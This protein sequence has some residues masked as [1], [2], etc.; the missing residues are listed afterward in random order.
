MAENKS[1]LEGTRHDR[2]SS[3][4]PTPDPHFQVPSPSGSRPSMCSFRPCASRRLAL[5]PSAAPAPPAAK[6]QKWIA[7]PL[8]IKGASL[9]VFR[10]IPLTAQSLCWFSAYAEL[11]P[12][13]SHHPPHAQD[14]ITRSQ[15][16]D[17]E[18]RYGRPRRKFS[19]GC[20]LPR[21]SAHS[22]PLTDEALRRVF[23]YGGDKIYTRAA[24]G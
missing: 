8:I 20:R 6:F 4:D 21:R 23:L 14:P 19:A 17:P 2:P 5:N 15:I 7:P 3:P 12:R 16:P 1:P 24:A 22:N 11:C 9:T 18:S 13:V 10:S